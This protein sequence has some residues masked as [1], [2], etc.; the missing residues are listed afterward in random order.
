MS[1]LMYWKPCVGVFWQISKNYCLYA[2]VYMWSHAYPLAV[3][4]WYWPKFD[5]SQDADMWTMH[6]KVNFEK[7][8]FKLMMDLCVCMLFAL[9]YGPSAGNHLINQNKTFI[10]S[11]YCRCVSDILSLSLLHLQELLKQSRESG[12]CGTVLSSIFETTRMEKLWNAKIKT[13]KV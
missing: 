12:D 8:L 3:L 6:C 9:S 13:P 1:S 5:R 10:A 11:K 7:M 2:F 4:L